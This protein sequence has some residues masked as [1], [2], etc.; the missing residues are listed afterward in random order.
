M[1]L[2]KK[3]AAPHKKLPTL[4]KNKAS[5]LSDA[6][7][8]QTTFSYFKERWS[9]IKGRRIGDTIKKMGEIYADLRIV[10]ENHFRSLRTYD[11]IA[12]Q[13]SLGREYLVLLIGSCVI[14]TFGLFQNSAAVIIG[15]MLIAPLMMPILGF[16]L[17]ILW[18][19]RDL[20]FDS[21]MTLTVSFFVVIALTIF[22]VLVI[23]GVEF[24]EQI[25]ARIH[26]NLY[27]I[28]IA[29]ASGLLGAYTFANPK[30]SD[31]ISGI[32][33]SVALMPPLCTIGISL[34]LGDWVSARGAVLLYGTNLI[35]ISL[36]ASLVF[37]QLGVHPITKGKKAVGKRAK[38][39]ILYTLILLF[40]IALPLGFFTRQTYIIKEKE[41][42]IREIIN[43]E[44][45]T[46]DILNLTVIIERDL[47]QVRAILI[48]SQK[49]TAQRKQGIEKQIRALFDIVRVDLKFIRAE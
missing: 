17:G 24:N 18:G 16:A 49:M 48:H 10:K 42:K 28:L 29:L 20:F 23:P 40:L 13:S 22:F 1:K 34:G 11:Y 4:D 2:S 15:A 6:V 3:G 5:E 33:I 39:K 7:E 27:D 9:A 37:W 36:A 43:A 46:V 21:L 26:P 41:E 35:S 38:K 25:S 12:G 31:S 19:E 44:I 14:T 45:R 32:A 47:Y 8:P 30:I